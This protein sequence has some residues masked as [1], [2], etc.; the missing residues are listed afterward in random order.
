MME[1]Q[2]LFIIYFCLPFHMDWP[3]QNVLFIFSINT[4]SSE[5]V[6]SFLFL[7][8]AANSDY[9][10][11]YVTEDFNTYVSRKRLEYTHGNHIE[12]QAMS[13]MYNRNIEV[14]CY[15]KGS[16]QILSSIYLII[17]LGLILV[18]RLEYTGCPGLKTTNLHVFSFQ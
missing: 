17:F 10:S 13:E 6:H 7:F 5:R 16:F 14:F 3:F 18:L 15:G 1:Q 2:I 4:K 12:M 11:Q 9:F 8:Q